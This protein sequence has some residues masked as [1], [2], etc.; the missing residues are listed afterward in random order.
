MTY[1][2][3]GKHLLGIMVVTGLLNLTVPIF[4]T[5]ATFA[6]G[7]LFIFANINILLFVLSKMTVKSAQKQLFTAV[8]MGGTLL[9]LLFSLSFLLWYET[10]AQPTTKWFVLP[11]LLYFVV[12]TTFETYFLGR[13]A[14]S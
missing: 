2:D 5:Y 4:I 3:F 12:F 10:T 11:F 14:K 9:K 7:S 1:T 6:W 13:I 8:F